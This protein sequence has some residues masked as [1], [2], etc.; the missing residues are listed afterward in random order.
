MINEFKYEKPKVLFSVL[1][2]SSSYIMYI[3]IIVYTYICVMYIW[4]LYAVNIIYKYKPFYE[5]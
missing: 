4:S 2:P 3:C 5:K 1:V